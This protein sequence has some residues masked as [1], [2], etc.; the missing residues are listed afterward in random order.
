MAEA[1]PGAI[2]AAAARINGG[3]PALRTRLT[4][5]PSDCSASHTSPVA[6]DSLSRRWVHAAQ[7]LAAAPAPGGSSRA[8]SPVW[9]KNSR[10]PEAM[11]SC[12][13]VVQPS[14]NMRRSIRGVRAG[15]RSGPQATRP[16][17]MLASQAR[18]ECVE[19]SSPAWRGFS[20]AGALGGA[21][22]DSLYF[23]RGQ[24][25]NRICRSGREAHHRG[26]RFT[27]A[28][29]SLH[30]SFSVD[31]ERRRGLCGGERLAAGPRAPVR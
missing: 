6:S 4:F 20:D 3:H 11:T 17:M 7:Q 13:L 16:P 24:E 15:S 27:S 23:Q 8:G 31:R 1:V 14:Y 26:K 5:L 22:D 9:R 29:M 18:R 10:R 12:T 30:R 21:P 28:H 19:S 2:A 25:I